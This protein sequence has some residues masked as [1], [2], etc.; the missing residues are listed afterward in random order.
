MYDIIII[1]A[2]PAGMTA[3]IYGKRAKKKILVLETSNY[4]G[5]IINALHIENYPA[6]EIISGFDYA[7]QLYEQTKKI[8]VEYQFERAI[9][10]ENHDKEKIVKTDQNEYHAKTV[11]IA[12]GANQ[13]RLGLANEK[14]LLGKGISYCATCDGNFY[15]N[16]VV[17][18][19]GGG[20]TA[21][22]DA[23]YLSNI[24]QKLYLIHRRDSF[25]ANQALVEQVKEKENIEILYNTEITKIIGENHLEKVE[26][27][28]NQEQ[29][30][31]LI[32]GLF[33]AIGQSPS[34]SF[35]QDIVD[36]DE[37]GYIIANESCQTKTEGIYVA[38]DTR[39]KSLRQL[40]TAA[41]DGAVAATQAIQYCEKK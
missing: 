29:K 40:V 34:N 26:I 30:E 6:I 2:G 8:G 37:Y 17:A 41:A 9:K 5:K 35:F 18:V 16:K 23:I 31:L 36:L 13:K 1:G 7:N 25:K 28:N 3:A 24:V 10:I 15:K 33:V 21:L 4:G 39:T 19:I 12:T 32:D 14:E 27:K 22:E 20:E 11:I 38:G